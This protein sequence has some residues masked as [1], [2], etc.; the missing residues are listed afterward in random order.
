[1]LVDDLEASRRFYVEVL[2][3]EVLMEHPGYVRIGGG[4]GFHIGMEEGAQAM[5]GAAGIE[6]SL[7]VE[8]CDAA[9]AAATGEGATT[10]SSPVDSD[11]GTRYAALLDPSG[12]RIS[13]QSE[14]RS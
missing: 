2:G 1:M 12:Y 10:V 14:L 7:W 9:F 3:L 8:D 13:L 6:I 4:D 5:I 11:W